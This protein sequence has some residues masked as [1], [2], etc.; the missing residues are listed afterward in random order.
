MTCPVCSKAD[1]LMTCAGCSGQKYCS[2][3]C[4]RH[5]WR[6]HKKECQRAARLARLAKLAKLDKLTDIEDLGNLQALE[7]FRARSLPCGCK[8][9]APA[10]K[11]TPGPYDPGHLLELVAEG[12]IT[13]QALV[14]DYFIVDDYCNIQ[15]YLRPPAVGDVRGEAASALALHGVCSNL[16]P[17]GCTISRPDRPIGCV[18][19]LP[20]RPDL[21]VAIDAERASIIWGGEL[22]KQ[23]L[24]AFDEENR[25]RNPLARLEKDVIRKELLA[26]T[27]EEVRAMKL[28][29]ILKQLSP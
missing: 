13:Y 15:F 7:C 24:Q 28:N 9:C 29:A 10:C 1:A 3:E 22:G 6:R 12:K 5:D 16:G 4:Q 8:M 11:N 18:T 26:V 25:Q 2:P 27:K 21:H 19:A 17:N 23:V 20:C 14:K